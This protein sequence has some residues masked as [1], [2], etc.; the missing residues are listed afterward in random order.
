LGST[1]VVEKERERRSSTMASPDDKKGDPNK[2]KD[3]EIEKKKMEE[4]FLHEKLEKE[5]NRTNDETN[6]RI[7]D[8]RW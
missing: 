5:K 6:A 8:G 1:V 3:L 4:N 2:L 7:N